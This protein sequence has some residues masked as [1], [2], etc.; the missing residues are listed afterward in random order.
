MSRWQQEYRHRSS[1]VKPGP[2]REPAKAPAP[3]PPP[4]WRVWL[5]VAGIVLT[6]LLFFI[7]SMSSSSKKNHALI[8]SDF[9]N[10]VTSDQVKTATITNS[11]HVSGDLTNGDTYT[12]QIPLAIQDDQLA[13]LLQTHKVQVKGTPS[14]G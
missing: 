6:L 9:V 7:P 5:I 14:A 11:G 4:K 8:Y 3:P 2:P 10:Q 1:P 12:T 13:P